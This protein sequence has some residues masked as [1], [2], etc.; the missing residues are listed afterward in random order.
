[1]TAPSPA[2]SVFTPAA[3]VSTPPA[4]TEVEITD[5]QVAPTFRSS[6]LYV[7]DSIENKLL[8][9]SDPASSGFGDIDGTD[10][11]GS[12][13]RSEGS[14]NPQIPDE[15]AESKD[16]S[17]FCGD[18]KVGVLAVVSHTVKLDTTAVSTISIRTREASSLF[19]P[20]K[21]EK[22][23]DIVVLGAKL[24]FPLV[25]TPITGNT[26]E[27]MR[28]HLDARQSFI[29][30]ENESIE[31]E[32]L[33]PLVQEEAARAHLM[34]G[35]LERHGIHQHLDP[36]RLPRR[37]AQP[38]RGPRLQWIQFW[39]CVRPLSQHAYWNIVLD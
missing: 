14:M 13:R 15:G 23:S 34:A 8:A 3:G 24:G 21:S 9:P 38:S 28:N 30:T 16:T 1:M 2:F 35:L 17:N 25:T 27:D 20:G 33:L 31:A 6:S 10:G 36:P 12:T 32:R 22:I 18:P 26:A 37:L 5:Q 39:A 29:D 7:V 19:G 11:E 4:M